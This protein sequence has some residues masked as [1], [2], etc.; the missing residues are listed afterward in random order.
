MSK[1]PIFNRMPAATLPPDFHLL[2]SHRIYAS[3]LVSGR[4][5]ANFLVLFP[6]DLKCPL[7]KFPVFNRMPAATI[8]SDSHLRP[9][10]SA[11]ASQLVSGRSPA[12]FLV[13]FDA[14]NWTIDAGNCPAATIRSDFPLRPC[15]SV[16]ASK[17]VAG[18]SR[19]NLCVVIPCDRRRPLP[20]N[21]HFRPKA[22]RA[23]RFDM[24]MH[25]TLADIRCAHKFPNTDASLFALQILPGES[26]PAQKMAIKGM[27][28]SQV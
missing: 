20:Q 24:A 9:S 16:H 15:R 10:S 13:L 19:A 11:Y 18:L 25:A 6:C 3:Q 14:G 17:L 27:Q 21:S 8:R 12:N 23:C 7:P 2:H 26:H 5:L 1:I 22:R 4:S 28:Q